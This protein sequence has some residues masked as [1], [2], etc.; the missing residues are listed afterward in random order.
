M[1][2]TKCGK[3]N[4][5]GQRFCQ[6]CGAPL[7]GGRRGEQ[8]EE[9][10]RRVHTAGT[11]RKSFSMR[12]LYW[13]LAAEIALAV[14]GVF[15]GVRFLS[16]RFSARQVVERYAQ[17]LED[18]NWG[19]AYDCLYMEGETGLSREEYIAAQEAKTPVQMDQ[20]TVS[21]VSDEVSGYWQNLEE[22]LGEQIGLDIGQTEEKDSTELEIR[23]LVNGD[24]QSQTVTA[25][26]TGKKWFF[27]DEWKIVPYNMYGEHVTIRIPKNTSVSINGQELSTEDL[28]RAEEE[29]G[30]S[31]YDSYIL[32][33]VFYGGY[34]IQIQQEGME[35]WTKLVEYNGGSSDF[36]FSS[37]SL[38]PEEE[39]ADQLMKQ[40]GEVSQKYFETAMA[41][42]SFSELEQYF[43]QDALESGEILD[44]FEDIRDN[45]YDSGKERGCLS[46]EISGL[47]GTV[48]PAGDFYG[49]QP[50]DIVLDITGTVTTTNVSG[51]GGPRETSEES[52]WQVCFRQE[53]GAWKLQNM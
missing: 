49:A 27:F 51:S 2:C 35:T 46:M 36:D 21:E 28:E 11:R 18:G 52:R 32:P 43:T 40:Y 47:Q 30:D 17:A 53:D 26:R 3:Q 39:T 8:R 14:L 4:Q 41:G 33:H 42:G 19:T 7:S 6:Y 25:V 45:T 5:D 50:G 13:V 15:L 48:V 20:V 44:D 1:F 24:M 37:V 22:Q 31:W 23:C 12:P 29:S 10:V 9:S 16:G 38:M 34:Q